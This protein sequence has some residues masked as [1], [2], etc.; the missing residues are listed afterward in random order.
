M[1]WQLQNMKS[2]HCVTSRS[3]RNTFVDAVVSHLGAAGTSEAFRIVG[4]PDLLY[5]GLLRAEGLQAVSSSAEGHIAALDPVHMGAVK[6]S[7]ELLLETSVSSSDGTSKRAQRKAVQTVFVSRMKNGL[8]RDRCHAA[9]VMLALTHQMW[10]NARPDEGGQL[11]IQ[12]FPLPGVLQNARTVSVTW[13]ASAW[14]EFPEAAGD[15]ADIPL[16]AVLAAVPVGFLL[17]NFPVSTAAVSEMHALGISLTLAHVQARMM[18]A[19]ARWAMSSPEAILRV[20][21]GVIDATQPGGR[22]AAAPEGRQQQQQVPLSHAAPTGALAGT[23]GQTASL[24]EAVLL[25]LVG[26]SIDENAAQSEGGAAATEGWQQQ[27]QVPL[28]HAAPTGGSSL[29]TDAAASVC[30]DELEPPTQPH[31]TIGWSAPSAPKKRRTDK[32]GTASSRAV[33]SALRQLR[34]QAAAQRALTSVSAGAY[35]TFFG[36]QNR[37]MSI[38]DAH[39]RNITSLLLMQVNDGRDEHDV[40]LCSVPALPVNA[41]AAWSE[42]DSGAAEL[43][44]SAAVADSMIE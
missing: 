27:Q 25:S 44:E 17:R 16:G 24:E 13:D 28:S 30:S 5:A 37:Y 36:L 21:R 18:M 23:G 42:E 4:A 41:P 34:T 20:A 29:H 43:V 1:H 15:S 12:S 33:A 10:Q 14:G 32:E 31:G 11:V 40:E 3:D 7:V 2:I 8:A 6:E 38:I 9:N 35:D 22:D 19:R 39:L 26:S